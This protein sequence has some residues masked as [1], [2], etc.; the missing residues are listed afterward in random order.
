LFGRESGGP[1]RLTAAELAEVLGPLEMDA[2]GLLTRLFQH[3]EYNESS[4]LPADDVA[5]VVVRRTA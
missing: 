3:A 5:V 1:P 4:D 2:A